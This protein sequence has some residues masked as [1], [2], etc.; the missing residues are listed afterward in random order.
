MS[1]L[2]R[3]HSSHIQIG[4]MQSEQIHAG[5]SCSATV[6][7]SFSIV[8]PL[9]CLGQMRKLWSR[10]PTGFSLHLLPGSTFP[11]F[12]GNGSLVVISRVWL[13]LAPYKTCG[14]TSIPVLN[15]STV[16]YSTAHASPPSPQF[17]MCIIATACYF[18][19]EHNHRCWKACKAS[20]SCYHGNLIFK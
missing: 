18:Y 13:S 2:L 4:H 20:V 8:R 16:G 12:W 6:G 14:L 1:S 19:W 3:I 11:F 5:A 15:L 9:L 7:Y 10:G 17:L